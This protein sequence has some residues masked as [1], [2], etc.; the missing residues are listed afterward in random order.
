MLVEWCSRKRVQRYGFFRNRQNFSRFFSQ[1]SPVFF[2]LLIYVKGGRRYTFINIY[3]K[4]GCRRIDDG[5]AADAPGNCTRRLQP[6]DG[7][8]CFWQS[9]QQR[10]PTPGKWCACISDDRSADGRRAEL[11]CKVT[12]K[13]RTVQ[14]PTGLRRNP[15]LPSH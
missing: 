2:R 7:C 11:W 8:P 10:Y 12:E 4:K 3:N 14:A 15:K 13:E 6:D 5:F 9:E 1:K